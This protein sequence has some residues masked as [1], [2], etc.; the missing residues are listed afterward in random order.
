MNPAAT[1][2]A[3][4]ED[5]T[6]APVPYVGKLP[7]TF[8]ALSPAEWR[9]LAIATA[10]LLL[11]TQIPPTVQRLA[12]PSDRVHVGNY[13][14]HTDFSAYRAAMLE[15]ATT[16]SWLIHNPATAEEHHP[17]LMFPLYVTLGKLAATTGLSTM[18][19][20]GAAET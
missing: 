7:G 16:P 15:G 9:W 13:W 14:Y 2:S 18:T 12:G 6:P 17:A 19:I 8:P 11:A 3:A 5:R 20:F 10:L 1:T 4:A